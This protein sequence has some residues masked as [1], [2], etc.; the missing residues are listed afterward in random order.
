MS[1]FVKETYLSSPLTLKKIQ[2]E[3]RFSG[4]A[5]VFN[6]LDSQG[7]RILKGAFLKSL[8][9]KE[10]PKMLWQH[11]AKEPI[12]IWHIIKEDQNGLYVEGQLLLDIQRGREAYSLLKKGVLDGLS[13]G[14]SVKDADFSGGEGARDLKEVELLEISLVTFAANKDAKVTAVKNKGILRRTDEY[15]KGLF[16]SIRRAIHVLRST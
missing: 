15:Q 4:Y 11:D 13:I 1:D 10:P 7:D 16:V 5:S 9:E 6:T 12:G 14:C 2:N 8:K 3:G